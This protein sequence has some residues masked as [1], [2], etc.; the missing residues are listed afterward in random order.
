MKFVTFHLGW[1]GGG[2]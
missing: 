2:G 1:V